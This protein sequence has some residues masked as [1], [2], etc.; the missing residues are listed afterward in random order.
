MK[1]NLKGVMGANGVLT[2]TEL[3]RRLDRR[4]LKLSTAQAS[5]IVSEMPTRLNMAL[6]HAVCMEFKCMPNDVIIVEHESG[7]VVDMNRAEYSPKPKPKKKKV[8]MDTNLTGP[9]VRPFPVKDN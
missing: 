6:L 9:S 4:G 1:W 3:M 7:E 2:A 5:R 8:D